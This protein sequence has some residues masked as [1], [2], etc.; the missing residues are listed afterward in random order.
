MV[1]ATITSVLLLLGAVIAVIECTPGGSAAA[2]AALADAP[3]LLQ[4]R[5]RAEWA[6][7]EAGLPLRQPL[8][9]FGGPRGS[10]KG[11]NASEGEGTAMRAIARAHASSSA[12]AASVRES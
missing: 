11:G 7:Q 3:R 1:L 12:A 4:E 5:L 10:R 2:S 8:P 6:F 9:D